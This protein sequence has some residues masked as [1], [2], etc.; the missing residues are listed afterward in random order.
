MQYKPLLTTKENTKPNGAKPGIKLK[1]Q[2][3]SS[4]YLLH[5]KELPSHMDE[6]ALGQLFL[7]GNLVLPSSIRV[8]QNHSER[9]KE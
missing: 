5:L 7:S 8:C 4:V 9:E 1:G 2:P 3:N 6:I